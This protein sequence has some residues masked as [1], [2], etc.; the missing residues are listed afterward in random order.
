MKAY[1]ILQKFLY[2]PSIGVKIYIQ[3][4]TAKGVQLERNEVIFPKATDAPH[5]E[6]LD[7]K[8][9]SFSINDNVLTLH[10]TP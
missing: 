6:M 7:R 5:R 9:E 2:G 4:G 3:A 10:V 8:L 1:Q